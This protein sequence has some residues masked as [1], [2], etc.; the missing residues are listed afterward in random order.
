MTG[1][2]GNESR[3]YETMRIK[4]LKIYISFELL[5]SPTCDKWGN[6]RAGKRKL[7][8]EQANPVR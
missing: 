8:E 6:I 4:K 5:A 2:D 1:K 3:R 7:S